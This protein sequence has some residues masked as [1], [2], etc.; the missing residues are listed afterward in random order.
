M[1]PSR[2]AKIGGGGVRRFTLRA[3]RP[4][5]FYLDLQLKRA[6]EPQPIDRMRVLIEVE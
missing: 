2:D 1:P 4:G 3:D 5:T 6:W